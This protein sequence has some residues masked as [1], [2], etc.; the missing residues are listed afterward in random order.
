MSGLSLAISAAACF[1]P[2]IPPIDGGD[3]IDGS[4]DSET[5]TGSTTDSG[6]TTDT[7]D[8]TCAQEGC[9]C[10]GPGACDPG[11]Y[12][13]EGSCIVGVCGDATTQGPEDCDDG[14]AVDGDGCDSDC[15]FTEV[16]AIAASRRNSCALIEGGR[17]RCWGANDVGQLG[18]GNVQTIGDDESPAAAGDVM[19]PEFAVELA[20]GDVHGCVRM[21]DK[22]LRCWGS[23]AGGRLGFGNGNDIG[24]DETPLATTDVPVGNDVVGLAAGASHNCARF[25]GGQLRCW[26]VGLGGRLGYGNLENIGDDEL[27]ADAG[28]VMV[29]GPVLAQA[30]GDA[31]TCAIMVSGA[32]R[33]WGTGAGGRLG[34]GNTSD[35]GDNE[36]PASA[37]EVSAVPQG[38]PP[39]TPVTALALGSDMS[40]ARFEGGAVSCWGG[41]GSGQLGR[42]DSQSIGDDELPSVQQPMALPGPALAIAAGRAHVC[43][44]LEGGDVLCWGEN[45]SGQLG[46]GHTQN[47]GDDELPT[48]GGFVDLGGPAVAV[49]AGG[50]HSCALLG[51]SNEVLCWGENLDGQLGLGHTE[52]IGDDEVPSD[53]GPIA[54][55]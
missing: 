35:I 14:N 49:T 7:T 13:F 39:V 41:N 18:Y 51:M 17:V 27:P 30:A 10:G 3:E 20:L 46:L 5:D 42:G 36:S 47:I 8:G 4:S 12:C 40:C 52:T 24:D 34:Y 44:L 22:G 50:D 43:A 38:L 6:S 9:S 2:G 11:L 21:V 31:H 26:G 32:V 16:M 48:A 15:S 53:A 29:G 37:G 54:L 28:D 45:G 25:G 55:F 23:A 19:L 33:C 1:N